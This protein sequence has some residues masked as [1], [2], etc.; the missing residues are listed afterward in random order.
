MLFESTGG[1]FGSSLLAAIADLIS[2]KKLAVFAVAFDDWNTK[3]EFT[4]TL[5]GVKLFM[6][7]DRS[8]IWPLSLNE[9]FNYKDL[10][11]SL[12]DLLI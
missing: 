7:T 5:P 6:V 8:P 1:M 4:I 12:F 9:L 2:F 10:K 3:F 11:E